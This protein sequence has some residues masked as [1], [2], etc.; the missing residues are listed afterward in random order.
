M[1]RLLRNVMSH[2]HRVLGL[3]A[4]LALGASLWSLL[5]DRQVV[6]AVQL[7]VSAFV[8]FGVG[9]VLA[10]SMHL[11]QQNKELAQSLDRLRATILQLGRRADRAPAA[12]PASAPT[13]PAAP[14]TSRDE[15]AILTALGT[16][17][18]D[19]EM[20]H[21]E[22]LELAAEVAR[23]REQAVGGRSDG[24]RADEGH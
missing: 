24:G 9:V 10:R 21:Q 22:L 16:L 7:L 12:A 13:P 15:E 2:W 17:R 11:R 3:V 8:T 23:L 5:V 6:L 19:A 18:L 4:A 20:R 1:R 14:T